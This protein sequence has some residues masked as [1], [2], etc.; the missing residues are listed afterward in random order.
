MP[1]GVN[2]GSLA[3][4]SLQEDSVA[5]RLVGSS[6]SRSTRPGGSTAFSGRQY[7][8]YLFHGRDDGK[9]GAYF[10]VAPSMAIAEKKLNLQICC[11]NHPEGFF[12]FD[13]KIAI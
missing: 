3:P 1:I 5:G 10:V 13:E 11:N 6:S 9:R 4:R 8:F 12:V 2:V 7:A